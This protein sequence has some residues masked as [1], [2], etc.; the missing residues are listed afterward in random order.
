MVRRL[1]PLLALLLACGDATAVTATA[2][3]TEAST[4]P[5]TTT[6]VVPTGGPT[7][8]TGVS[9]E[10]DSEGLTGTTGEPPPPP[11]FCGQLDVSLALHPALDIYDETTRAAFQQFLTD[12]VEQ[13]GARVRVL[14]N[15]GT[16]MLV[17]TD[18]L[19]P[20]GNAA[21]DPIL[22]YGE[23]GA[24]DP[25]AA[26]ALDCSLTALDNYTSEFDDGD[27]HFSGLL[28]PMLEL[29]EWP[30]PGA[31]SLAVLAAL[32]DEMQ[33]NMYAQPGTAAEAYLRR[34]AD[35][36]RRR[37]AALT[38]GDVA[39][40]LEIFGLAVSANS[41][42]FERSETPL[43]TA[44]AEWT[45]V[46][47]KTCEDFDY[48]PPFDPE[49]PTGCERVDVLFAIDGS[50]SMDGE[51]DAL[52]GVD[53]MPA[54][55]AEFTDALLMELTDVEDFHVGVVSS[56]VGYTQMHTHMNFPAT[57]EGPDSACNVPPGQRYI[58][59]PSPS[60]AEDF[61]C[62][63][64]TDSKDDTEVTV[65]NL[66]EALHDPANAGFL[67][68]DSL[69]FAVIL[70]DE[71]TDDGDLARMVEIRQSILDAVGGDLGRVLVLAIAG[72][73]GT[74]EAPETTCLG[75]YGYASPGRRIASI[76]RSFRER[77]LFQNLCE[78]DIPATFIDVL[79]DVV[80]ACEAYE[81]VG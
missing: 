29:P 56:E 18:C 76:V 46:A 39:G 58:V 33:N 16:E 10:G 43:S 49:P 68:D 25:D 72:G 47:A 8:T 53:G 4:G 65:Y 21:D 59:G 30:A 20:F 23:A 26:G 66:S 61:A 2:T 7:P 34:V 24:V 44:L 77:G 27:W 3:A 11:T 12:L 51:Q 36:D 64:A 19:L 37:L 55:F 45:P 41:R 74:F 70:T 6:I 52:R 60:F 67:R 50:L 31:T 80:S 71:D 78:G 15:V 73:M 28:F 57:P 32:D 81:P 5:G 54:V 63:A 75:V 40:R 14:P 48:E 13:T 62:I 1:A 17:H 69:L 35:G 38:Y 9:T 22:V 79:D 42:H